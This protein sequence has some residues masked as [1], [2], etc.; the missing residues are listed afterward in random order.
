MTASFSTLKRKHH[1]DHFFLLFFSLPLFGVQLVQHWLHTRR[2]HPHVPCTPRAAGAGRVM[3]DQRSNLKIHQRDTQRPQNIIQFMKTLRNNGSAA[4]S[5]ISNPRREAARSLN[6]NA[7]R[8]TVTRVVATEHFAQRRPPFGTGACMG[9]GAGW[10]GP[11]S[12]ACQPG[13]LTGG[14]PPGGPSAAVHPATPR[15]TARGG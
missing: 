11:A 5:F 13:L 2:R 8:T 4:L 9:R 12:H 7:K 14:T 1:H 15:S 3:L 6:P 10:A